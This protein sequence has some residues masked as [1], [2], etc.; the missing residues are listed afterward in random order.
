MHIEEQRPP[1]EFVLSLSYKEL[2]DLY[3]IMLERFLECDRGVG[4]TEDTFFHA[5][6]E[7]A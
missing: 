6:K 1:P 2:H 3:R 7:F 4:S 5:L